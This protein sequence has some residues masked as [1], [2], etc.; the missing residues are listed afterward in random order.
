MCSALDYIV[1]LSVLLPATAFGPFYFCFVFFAVYL[2]TETNLSAAHTAL[3]LTHNFIL[4]D[5]GI[6]GYRWHFFPSTGPD[7]FYD[8]VHDLHCIN[9]HK[10][11]CSYHLARATVNP[12]SM[13]RKNQMKATCEEQ[14]LCIQCSHSQP[15]AESFCYAHT[16]WWFYDFPFNSRFVR[17]V[18]T[19]CCW[20]FIIGKLCAPD[21]RPFQQPWDVQLKVKTVSDV[22][23]YTKLLNGK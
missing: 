18:D 5:P 7:D 11:S 21:V 1:E 13:R 14:A 22:L 4:S 2:V 3:S 20:R 15:Q 9:R 10:A 23:P 19:C 12:A 6:G 8:G 16:F 17:P